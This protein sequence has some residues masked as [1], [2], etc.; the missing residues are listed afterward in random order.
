MGFTSQVRAY[1]KF[2]HMNKRPADVFIFL[3]YP[4]TVAVRETV[5]IATLLLDSL[6]HQELCSTQ[7]AMMRDGICTGDVRGILLQGL[8]GGERQPPRGLDSG[9]HQP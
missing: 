9:W 2:L 1:Y 5:R 6:H 3:L 4:L 8:Q 7:F